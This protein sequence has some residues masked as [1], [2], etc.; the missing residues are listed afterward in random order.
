M[1]VVVVAAAGFLAANGVARA[2]GSA[3]GSGVT[4]PKLMPRDADPGWEVVTVRPSDPNETNQSFR[5][6]GRHVLI[7]RQTV[8]YMLMVAYGLQK[9]QI[10]NAPEWVKTQSFDADGV[11]D[12]EG[13]PSVQQFQVMVRKLLE[14]RFGLKAHKEQ[15]EMEVYALRVGKDGPKLAPTKSDPNALPSQNAHGGTG[16][17]F[18]EFTNVSMDDFALMML[19]E[20]QRPLVNQTGLKGRYDFNLKFTNDEQRAPT[21]SNAAPGLFTAVQEQL[22]L[23][24]DAVKAP[25]PVLV[26]DKV[27][28]P[29]AN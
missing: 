23:K 17:R 25:A 5:V 2:Q 26:V 15:R 24:L 1:R 12:T 13:Q 18:L 22:G 19:Y 6:E 29:S 16:D 3:A 10:A 11:P 20:V 28:R 21:D 27:E 7:Q 9:N 4:Q 14:Q 8:E